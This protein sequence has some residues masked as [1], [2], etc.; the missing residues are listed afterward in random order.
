MLEN[1]YEIYNKTKSEDKITSLMYLLNY[2][3]HIFLPPADNFQ[4]GITVLIFC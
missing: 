1:A 4:V 3:L 2:I